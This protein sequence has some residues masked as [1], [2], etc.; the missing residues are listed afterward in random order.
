MVS[1]FIIFTPILGEM[2]Q[3]DQHFSN[4]FVQPPPSFRC[5]SVLFFSFTL[6]FLNRYQVLQLSLVAWTYGD[7]PMKGANNPLSCC[8]LGE[9]RN[10][11]GG[12]KQ[13]GKA[14]LSSNSLM[15]TI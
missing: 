12:L 8:K 9:G 1:I 15:A 10:L 6:S 2:I 14:N 4:G 3:F 11:F 5:P 13:V 7:L